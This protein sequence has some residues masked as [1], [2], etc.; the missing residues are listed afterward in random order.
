MTTA[1][2]TQIVAGAAMAA[3]WASFASEHIA[4]FWLSGKTSLLAFGLAETLTAIFFLLRTRPRTFTMNPFE[5]VIALSGTFLPLLLRPTTAEPVAAA[6]IGLILGSAFQIA[7]TLSLN[8]SFA[9]VPALRDLKTGGAYRF[10]RHPLY[11]SYVISASSY[12]AVN[13]SVRNL[14]L[15]LASFGLTLARIHFEE[16]HLSLTPEYR[17]YRDR[18]AWRLIPFV[19]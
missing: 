16:R 14:L 15:I 3:L 19:F 9:L 2:P 8:R 1:A 10:V 13:F 12:L 5:W 6:E 17:A 4:G 7:G 18:V 11:L